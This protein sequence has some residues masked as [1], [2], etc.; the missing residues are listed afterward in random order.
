MKRRRIASAWGLLLGPL[1]FLS[2]LILYGL[3]SEHDNWPAILLVLALIS[4]GGVLLIWFVNTGLAKLKAK[5][6]SVN[7]V[8]R[9]SLAGLILGPAFFALS[10]LSRWALPYGDDEWI[11]AMWAVIGISF[12]AFVSVHAAFWVRS[13]FQSKT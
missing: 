10:I 12:I 9:L 1:W 7:G 5:L 6:L 4:A 11:A 3:P 2:M 13:A 8:W